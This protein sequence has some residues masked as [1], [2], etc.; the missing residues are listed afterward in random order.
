MNKIINW[1]QDV[2][3]NSNYVY[4]DVCLLVPMINFLLNHPHLKSF[5][6]EVADG[7]AQR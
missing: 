1:T 7:G 2:S 6:E 3:P 5:N 4:P